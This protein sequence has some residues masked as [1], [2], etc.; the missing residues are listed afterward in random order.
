MEKQVL[1]YVENQ[2]VDTG[3]V[4]KSDALSSKKVK[5][6]VTANEKTHASIVYSVGVMK[7]STHPTEAQLFY[8]DLQTEKSLKTFINYDF[9]G[10]D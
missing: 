10:L 2:N 5:I 7:D 9:K 6:V 3:V 8:D 1:T 4:Y